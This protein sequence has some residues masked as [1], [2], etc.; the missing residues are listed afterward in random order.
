M[1]SINAI[2]G[3]IAI[4]IG[5]IIL[6]FPGFAVVSFAVLIGIGLLI[7]GIGRVAVG[8]GAGMSGGVRALTIIFGLIVAILGLIIIFI[9]AIGVYTYAFFTSIAF[10]IIGFDSLASGIMGVTLT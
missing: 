1:R 2:I 8:G 5:A 7:Y 4:I 10:F 9:P 6:F 3:L